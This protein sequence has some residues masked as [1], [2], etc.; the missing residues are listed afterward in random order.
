MHCIYPCTCR[1][2]RVTRK[3]VSNSTPLFLSFPVLFILEVNFPFGI[4]HILL[5]PRSTLRR[6]LQ[7]TDA[8]RK[9]DFSWYQTVNWASSPSCTLFESTANLSLW[10]FGN[11][12]VFEYFNMIFVRSAL[13]WV[14]FEA[15]ASV[16]ICI[17][18]LHCILKI[19]LIL[20]PFS[21]YFYPRLTLLYFLAYHLYFYSVPYG[22]FALRYTFFTSSYLQ[23]TLLI[24]RYT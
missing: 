8:R 24:I 22:F 10:I 4:V 19:S 5:F 18:F 1:L 17:S 16:A 13:R 21:A 20:S 3:K 2:C 14:R 6:T 7:T 9:G 15:N 23:C 11:A 12:M